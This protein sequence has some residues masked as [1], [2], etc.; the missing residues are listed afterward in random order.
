[1][2]D[3]HRRLLALKVVVGIAVVAGAGLI[4]SGSAAFAQRR[5]PPWCAYLGG[6]AGGY[7][8]SYYNFEQ[9]ME[10]ARGLGNTCVPNPYALHVPDQ[11]AR[12]SRQW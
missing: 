9:C 2:P 6:Q 5:A 1:M 12:R 3:D 10:T 11:R 7:D 4:D 8:C